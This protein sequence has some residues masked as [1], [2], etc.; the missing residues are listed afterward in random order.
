MIYLFKIFIDKLLYARCYS[1][2]RIE[3][4][5]KERNKKLFPHDAC[6]LVETG[7]L[8]RTKQVKHFFKPNNCCMSRKASLKCDI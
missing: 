4:K 6:F 7:L 1:G 2:A 8:Q 5:N 3:K